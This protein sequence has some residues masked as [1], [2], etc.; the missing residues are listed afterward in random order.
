MTTDELLEMLTSGI[1]MGDCISNCSNRGN[2]TFLNNRKYICKCEMYFSGQSCQIDSRPCSSKPCINNGTCFQNLTTGT[3]N[4]NCG[5]FYEGIYCHIK[6]D[7]CKNETCS[8]NGNCEDLNNQAI[9][10]CFSMY[11]GN[12]CEIESNEKKVIKS[13]VSTASIIAILILVFFYLTFVCCDLF[14]FFGFG[15]RNSE[16]NRSRDD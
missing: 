2:C 14:T 13:V 3:F 1:D 8:N 6:K 9:C 4:C 16:F 5:D 11:L 7:V 10:S 12:K 15:R